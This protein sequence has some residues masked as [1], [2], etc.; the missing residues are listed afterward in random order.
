MAVI[1]LLESE[2]RAA[3][4]SV[5]LSVAVA[6]LRRGFSQSRKLRFEVIT[7]PIAQPGVRS[8]AGDRFWENLDHIL[9]QGYLLSCLRDLFP[10]YG[11]TSQDILARI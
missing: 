11:I 6:N 5:Q 4:W 7:K 8:S 3:D 10:L 1:E 2:K 9:L